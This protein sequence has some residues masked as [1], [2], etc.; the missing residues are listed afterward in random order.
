[1][2]ESIRANGVMEPIIV[3]PHPSEKGKY[4]I[5]SGHNRVAAAKEAGKDDIPAI[6]HEGLTD[7]EALLIVTETNLMQR[8]FEALK[9][10]ERA[11]ALAAQYDVMKKNPGYRSDLLEEIETLTGSP[12]ANRM[13][14]MDKLGEQ[15]GLSKDTIARYLRVIRLIPTLMD[16]LDNDEIAMRAVVSLSYLRETEQE[17]VEGL[18]GTGLKISMV[19]AET[20]R[21][22]SAGEEL[23]EA[24]IG[25]LLKPNAV[26]VR[27]KN[28]KLSDELFS[29]YFGE[30]KSREEIEEII[31]KALA[32]YQP[33]QK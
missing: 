19:Q 29:R 20:L 17:I 33:D 3:Q 11:V 14:T 13:R 5:L 16:R 4:E 32:Q 28:V 24:A 10:S 9:H 15:F 27:S 1:M 12:V 18:L 31:S 25:V 26:K 8:V 22:A 30:G 6:I 2:V 7:E 21:K 23:D